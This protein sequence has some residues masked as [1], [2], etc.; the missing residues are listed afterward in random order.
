M[1][2]QKVLALPIF[3]FLVWFN[4]IIDFDFHDA[5]LLFKVLA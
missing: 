1:L 5:A 3:H 4:S 2:E